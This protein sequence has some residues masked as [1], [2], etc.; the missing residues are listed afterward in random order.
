[1]TFWMNMPRSSQLCHD[2]AYRRAEEAVI[3]RRLPR[4]P[5]RVRL[6]DVERTI[7]Q[8]AELIATRQI[9]L[10][11]LRGVILIFGCVLVAGLFMRPQQRARNLIFLGSADDVDAPGLDVRA[12]WR[13]SGDVENIGDRLLWHGPA[14][15]GATGEAPS[16]DPVDVRMG[17]PAAAPWRGPGSRR[18][19]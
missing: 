4:T 10:R 15:E 12:A 19:R 6:L 1:M 13:K 9:R 17:F 14:R 7:K 5:G 16:Y 3:L 11:Q 2:Q 8:P 18:H